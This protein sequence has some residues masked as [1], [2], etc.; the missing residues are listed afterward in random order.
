MKPSLFPAI[1]FPM[2]L[3]AC[4]SSGNVSPNPPVQPGREVITEEM[5]QF[6]NDV[7]DNAV[8]DLGISGEYFLDW[9]LIDAAHYPTE[10]AGIPEGWWILGISWSNIALVNTEVW[11][12][13]LQVAETT[14]H[15]LQHIRQREDGYTLLPYAKDGSVIPYAN[16]WYEVEAKCYGFRGGNKYATSHGIEVTQLS[17]TSEDYWCARVAEYPRPIP[18]YGYNLQYKSSKPLIEIE[19]SPM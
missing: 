8:I 7:G 2:L 12:D 13:R 4:G 16:R 1:L 10:Y 3:S 17:L 19:A 18:D 14:Y 9:D 5:V 6:L 11:P 15:E